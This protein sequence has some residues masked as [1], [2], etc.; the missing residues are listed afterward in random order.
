MKTRRLMAMAILAILLMPAVVLAHGSRT[1]AATPD[2]IQVVPEWLSKIGV[3]SYTVQDWN[4]M[5]SRFD[6]HAD[7]KKAAEELLGIDMDKVALVAFGAGVLVNQNPEVAVEWAGKVHF[8]R[9][10]K[11]SEGILGPQEMSSLGVVHVFARHLGFTQFAIA[12]SRAHGGQL[13]PVFNRDIVLNAK[14]Q[15]VTVPAIDHDMVRDVWFHF[16][17]PPHQLEYAERLFESASQPPSDG[18]GEGPPR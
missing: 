16:Q 9:G 10:R 4:P 1:P 11:E 18:D 3:L 7:D 5:G 8:V 2:G 15:L 12:K 17:I 13:Q 6:Y 14:T